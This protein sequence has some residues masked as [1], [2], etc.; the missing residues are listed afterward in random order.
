MPI[1]TVDQVRQIGDIQTLIHWRL[2]VLRWPQALGAVM[3]SGDLDLR[4]VS[5]SLPTRK[6]STVTVQIRGHKSKSPGLVDVSGNI[7]LQLIETVDSRIA[8]LL[9]DW[10][11][12]CCNSR[13]GLQAAKAQVE[14]LLQI[15]RLSR[16]GESVWSYTLVGCFLEGYDLPTLDGSSNG[17][18]MPSMNISYDYFTDGRAG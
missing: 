16:G 5:T 18:F 6:G 2:N 12:L 7:S 1:P 14:A 11:E 9:R 3:A 10:S 17:N 4:C 8:T 13:T 15:T